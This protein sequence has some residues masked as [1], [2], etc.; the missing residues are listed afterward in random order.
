ML[1]LTDRAATILKDACADNSL[2]L[3]IAVDTAGCEGLQYQLAL[4]TQ[5]G[6]TDEILELSGIRVFLDRPSTLWLAGVTI[7]YV[8][9]ED[10]AGF[11]F[12][13]PN[14]GAKCACSG[15]CG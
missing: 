6:D 8:D 11:I 3:R 10:G 15:G 5:G 4:Q 13:N 7:D 2:G 9:A 12:D 1:T 14:A